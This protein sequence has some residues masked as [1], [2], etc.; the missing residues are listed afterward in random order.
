MG[1]LWLSVRPMSHLQFYCA[2]LSHNIISRQNL[3]CDIPCRTLQLCR[4]KLD[5]N[6]LVD[7]ACTTS[8]GRLFHILTILLVKKNLCR[9]Y[10]VR[11]FCNLKSLPFI[12]RVDYVVKFGT[13]APRYNAHQCNAHSDITRI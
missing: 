12:V 7:S 5:L 4:I 1:R 9:S 8:L 10:L 6:V 13:V 2:T 3:K 11:F